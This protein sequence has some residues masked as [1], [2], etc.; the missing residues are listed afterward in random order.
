MRRGAAS[1]APQGEWAAGTIVDGRYRIEGR[2]G[3]GA[4]ATV[5]DAEHLH[6][7][8][9]VAIKV[10]QNTLEKFDQAR[11][12]REVRTLAAIDHPNVCRVTDSGVFE[13]QPY[14]VMERLEG[15]VVGDA[16]LRG[17]L[18]TIEEAI[19]I[20]KQIL[21]GLAAA[22]DIGALHRDVKPGNV[23]LLDRDVLAV[24]IF[25]FGLVKP[26]S[27]EP[28]EVTE[29][30][31]TVGTP[32]Y[33]APEQLRGRRDLDGRCDVYGAGATLFHMLA[34][35]PPFEDT[36][37]NLLLRV[38][39]GQ[40]LRLNEVAPGLDPQLVEVVHRSMSLDRDQRYGSAE[41]FRAALDGIAPLPDL[42]YGDEPDTTPELDTDLLPEE[43]RLAILKA[44]NEEAA[45]G[46]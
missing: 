37:Q 24:K 20:T 27:I 23:M 1:R 25:D 38:A 45:K 2:I 42:T 9:R 11:F 46:K 5:Y 29:T 40:H 12:L 6:M 33:M 13:D 36:G 15:V 39:R 32:L 21:I 30:G 43:L 4:M 18:F 17:R 14:M 7:G 34:R 22:H 10:P 31:I 26:N 44:R 35:Q 28:G 19:A 16:M 3:R 41:E 8:R